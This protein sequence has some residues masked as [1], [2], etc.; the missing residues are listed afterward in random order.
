MIPI[1]TQLTQ[2]LNEWLLNAGVGESYAL[3]LSTLIVTS[4]IL[5]IAWTANF[6]VKKILLVQ[7][8][9]YIKKS[10]F[11]W[12][13][14]IVEKK[15]LKRL[16][17]FAPV[18]FIYYTI[19]IALAGYPEAVP[20]VRDILSVIMIFLGMM[21]IDA[22]LNVLH[23]FYNTL[24]VAKEKTIKS[25]IQ[26]LKI[27]IYFVGGIVILSV[28][29]GKSPLVFFT[30]LG[31]MA[32]VLM[33]VF[34]DTIL[35][36][37]AGIQITANQLVRVGDWIEMPEKNADGIVTDITVNTVKVRNWDKTI[38]S[39][40]TYSLVSESFINWRGM[41][42]SGGRRIKRSVNID[43]KSVKF[44]TPGML[45][46]FKRI[47]ILRNYIDKKQEELEDYNKKH[48]IDNSV[49]VNGRRQTNL[50]VFRQYI[51][52][53]LQRHP[54]VHNDMTFLVRHLQSTDKGVPVEIFVFCREQ[55][56]PVYESIQADIFDHI[57]AAVPEFDL[58][59]FQNPTGEDFRRLGETMENKTEANPGE[60]S[61]KEDKNG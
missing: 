31:A 57:I 49:L 28:I 50:G 16:A 6:I 34:K 7:I 61:L 55:S 40:P 22:L 58:R 15:L 47:Q 41:E 51:T 3:L 1:T 25:Y 11:S 33:L 45:E 52:L 48:G 10:G 20:V 19:P 46:K 42:E 56:W 30:G 39:F 27:I 53:Y 24:P 32:A 38:S 14:V 60:T 59:V 36:F 13:N 44:C 37:V 8:R 18:L 54:K 4:A 43:L 12:D 2:L 17:N 23:V 26:I 9:H 21:A 35:G 29:I 5:L